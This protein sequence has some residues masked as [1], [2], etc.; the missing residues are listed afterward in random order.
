M[1]RVRRVARGRVLRRRRATHVLLVVSSPDVAV[2][3][4]VDV[5]DDDVGD[6]E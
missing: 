2:V 3:D 6:S 5:D 4:D 1:P